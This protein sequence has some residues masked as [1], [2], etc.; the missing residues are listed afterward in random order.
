MVLGECEKVSRTENILL[1]KKKKPVYR[2]FKYAYFKSLSLPITH[3]CFMGLLCVCVY[4]C[5]VVVKSPCRKINVLNSHIGI[6]YWLMYIMHVI[7]LEM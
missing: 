6:L 2:H 4:V 7:Y 3:R 1:P 5:C